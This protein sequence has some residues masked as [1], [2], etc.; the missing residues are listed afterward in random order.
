[1]SDHRRNLN[2]NEEILLWNDKNI[3][4]IKNLWDADK[5]VLRWSFN[6]LEA[7]DDLNLIKSSL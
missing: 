4:H 7:K 2:G 3:E 1:M 5:V 6:V